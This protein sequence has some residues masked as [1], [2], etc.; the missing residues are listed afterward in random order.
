M[1]PESGLPV[2]RFDVQWEPPRIVLD[3]PMQLAKLLQNREVVVVVDPRLPSESRARLSRWLDRSGVHATDPHEWI[4]GSRDLFRASV[5]RDG[6]MT[7]ALI[8][9]PVASTSVDTEPARIVGDCGPIL[10]ELGRSQEQLL[11]HLE[12]FV[13][14]ADH[15]LRGAYR[16]GLGAVAAHDRAAGR[17]PQQSEAID[18]C[19][20]QG[21]CPGA[22][23]LYFQ[24]SVFI[25]LPEEPTLAPRCT[26]AILS[27]PAVRDAVDGA[28]LRAARKL[29]PRGVDTS[30]RVTAMG[31]IY[32]ALVE[33]CR[34]QR[35][36]FAAEDLAAIRRQIDGLG[37]LLT[38][39][40][41]HEAYGQWQLAPAPVKMVD[42][43][44][45][46]RI[47]RYDPAGTSATSSIPAKA[48]ELVHF[49]ETH[50]RCR[51]PAGEASIA[52]SVIAPDGAVLA[53]FVF[54]EEQ[55]GCGGGS[56]P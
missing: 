14:A 42:G 22:P 11:T 4:E 29:D 44:T 56:E 39:P 16:Q 41:H 40:T 8:V 45:A 35:R 27:D 3:D 50:A 7:T 2:A 37:R 31:S 10:R 49:V 5:D 25:G 30:D 53:G 9:E 26:R 28:L 12:P 18:A 54:F 19:I 15:T 13:R 17:C 34:P 33:I 48:D 43:T 6:S 36:W 51:T 38:R 21:Q 1:H 32:D 55:L 52:A 24:R 23:R 20:E 46:W 47:A